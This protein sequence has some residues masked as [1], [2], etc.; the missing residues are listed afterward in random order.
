MRERENERKKEIKVK[1]GRERERER[2]GE[3][4]KEMKVI[5]ERVSK[6]REVNSKEESIKKQY[7]IIFSC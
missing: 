4:E 3:R 2:E 1:K 5:D 7:S 6:H